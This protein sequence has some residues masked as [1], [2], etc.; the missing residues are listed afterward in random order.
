MRARYMANMMHV[1]EKTA[2]LL[3]HV[4]VVDHAE[5]VARDLAVDRLERV[6]LDGVLCSAT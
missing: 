5:H 1:Y 3:G 6:L 4:D 2:N